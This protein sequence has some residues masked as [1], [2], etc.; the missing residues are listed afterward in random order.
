MD[1][2]ALHAALATLWLSWLCPACSVD[3][4]PTD[5]NQ[6]NGGDGSPI[7]PWDNG[8]GGPNEETMDSGSGMDGGVHDGGDAG[9]EDLKTLTIDSDAGQ[10][11]LFALVPAC[12]STANP[13]PLLVAFH[14]EGE[15]AVDFAAA[16]GI[17]DIAAGQC[18]I[19]AFPTTQDDDTADWMASDK[20]YV[21]TLLDRLAQEYEIDPL[22]IFSTGFSNGGRMSLASAIDFDKRFVGVAARSA[23]TPYFGMESSALHP[24]P[25][26]LVNGGN[27]LQDSNDLTTFLSQTG[28]F[29]KHVVVPGQGRSLF[30]DRSLEEW[31]W[32]NENAW[33]K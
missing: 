3:N 7:N 11:K 15:S 30:S 21:K 22:R 27:D 20:G 8:G 31:Q 29:V 26:F 24:I 28:H 17:L 6:Q 16:S 5:D 18:F 25:V 10:R 23:G 2:R 4:T 33:G 12:T 19:A 13:S 9:T 32:L 14:G 1:R